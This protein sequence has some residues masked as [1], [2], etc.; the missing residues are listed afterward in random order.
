MSMQAKVPI[1]FLVVGC[2]IKTKK[3]QKQ[4]LEVFL[5]GEKSVLFL[6]NFLTVHRKTP[7]L[8]SL[9]NKVADPKA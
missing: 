3:M 8:E 2:V 5:F 9:F 4:P 7:V 6:Q 1:F